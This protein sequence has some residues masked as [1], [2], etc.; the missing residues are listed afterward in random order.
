MRQCRNNDGIQENIRNRITRLNDDLKVR[1][2]SINV[3]KS[4]LINQITGI[5]E[6]ISKPLDKDTSLAEKIQMLFRKKALQSLLF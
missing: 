4:R 6:T 1:Q 2:E 3:L 5:K